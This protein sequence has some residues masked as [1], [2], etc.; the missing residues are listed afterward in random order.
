MIFVLRTQVTK[1]FW[2]VQ[3]YIDLMHRPL[4]CGNIVSIHYTCQLR[5]TSLICLWLI[6]PGMDSKYDVFNSN[7]IIPYLR[8]LE[9]K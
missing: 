9:G 7:G 6:N 1:Q 5:Q 2:L 4:D 8:I 3:W